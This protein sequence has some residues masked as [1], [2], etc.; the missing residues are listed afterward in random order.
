MVESYYLLDYS[1]TRGSLPDL[2]K[3]IDKFY[4]L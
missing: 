2:Q 3:V 1:A 4:R